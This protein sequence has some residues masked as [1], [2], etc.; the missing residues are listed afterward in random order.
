M[1]VPLDIES[2]LSSNMYI[3][4]IKNSKLDSKRVNMHKDFEFS[5]SFW[6]I[7]T[8]HEHSNDYFDAR[9]H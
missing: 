4:K 6:V 7:I 2:I 3:V 1:S 5:S 9:S 8:S